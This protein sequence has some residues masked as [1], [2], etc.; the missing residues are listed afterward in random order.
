MTDHPDPDVQPIDAV[1]IAGER[2]EAWPALQRERQRQQ[3]LDIAAAAAG[4]AHRHRRLA[5]GEKN[6][7]RAERLA[8]A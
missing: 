8:I 1:G 3:E 7:R 2:I 6:A 4:T 5:A